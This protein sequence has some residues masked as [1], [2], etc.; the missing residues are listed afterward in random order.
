M[1]KLAP[2]GYV[3]DPPEA[4]DAG[5]WWKGSGSPPLAGR[6]PYRQRRERREQF[7]A[8]VQM[9]GS[10]HYWCGPDHPQS[11]LIRLGG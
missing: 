8:L 3:I 11:C 9:D 2:E 6:S 7:G 1:E 10:F 5:Y 4:G